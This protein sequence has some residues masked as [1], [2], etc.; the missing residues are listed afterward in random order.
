M[1]ALAPPQLALPGKR[2]EMDLYQKVWSMT[3]RNLAVL[4]RSPDEFI[5]K[6]G[7]MYH[8]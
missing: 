2:H 5:R 8:F 1:T 6:Y 7:D 4:R 3:S